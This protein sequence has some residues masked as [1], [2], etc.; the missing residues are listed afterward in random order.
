MLLQSGLPELAETTIRMATTYAGNMPTQSD[1]MTLRLL[2][3]RA[4]R[5]CALGQ[6]EE[7]ETNAKQA[8]EVTGVGEMDARGG[9]MGVK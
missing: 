8:L 3:A 9:C 7:S 4:R 5:H 6:L 2:L 1:G